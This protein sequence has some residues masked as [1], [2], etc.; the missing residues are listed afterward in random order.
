VCKYRVR[1]KLAFEIFRKA[2]VAR[3]KP[4]LVLI[5]DRSDAEVWRLCGRETGKDGYRVRSHTDRV[6]DHNPASKNGQQTNP[7]RACGLLGVSL[8]A[9]LPSLMKINTGLQAPS[10][11]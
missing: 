3:Y 7:A 10:V 11:L 9:P 6:A 2:A 4:R 5:G 1:S 8:A